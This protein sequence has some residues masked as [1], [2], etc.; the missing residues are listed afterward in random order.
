M[1]VRNPFRKTSLS[2][3]LLFVI[4]IVRDIEPGEEILVDYGP[5]YFSLEE[6]V[7][8]HKKHKQSATAARA[9]AR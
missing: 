7:C 1:K 5:T 8:A 6:C 9:E 3:T 4:Q 2:L